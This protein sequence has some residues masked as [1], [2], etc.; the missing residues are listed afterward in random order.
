[1]E[2]AEARGEAR[3]QLSDEE[4][5]KMKSACGNCHKGDAFR[6]ASCPFLGKPAYNPDEV[7]VIAGAEEGDGVKLEAI[8]D[9]LPVSGGPT[10]M[11]TTKGS[12]SAVIVGLDDDLGF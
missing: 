7:P 9:A 10:S 11:T 1:M 4:L 6:C 12:G 5:A 3:P 8:D 2:E